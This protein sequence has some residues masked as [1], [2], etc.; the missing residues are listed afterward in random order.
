MQGAHDTS[1]QRDAPTRRGG[2]PP[3]QLYAGL[4]DEA[5]EAALA[6]YCVTTTGPVVVELSDPAGP[7]TADAAVLARM[8][9][10]PAAFG[11]VL[12]VE[13]EHASLGR[14]VSPRR[15]DDRR[16]IRRSDT[17]ASARSAP[18]TGAGAGPR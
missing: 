10:R 12:V 3:F 4:H 11:R 16:P 9:R 14:A 13:G 2:Y 7:T 18:A 1:G 8:G 15:H 6:R 17:A 5:L